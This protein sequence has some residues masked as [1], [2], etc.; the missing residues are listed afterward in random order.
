MCQS[1][2]HLCSQTFISVNHCKT[3]WAVTS[4]RQHWQR[5]GSAVA[6]T[7]SQ[8]ASAVNGQ[9]QRWQLKCALDMTTKRALPLS[10]ART[11]QADNNN[12]ESGPAQAELGSESGIESAKESTVRA[13][14][15]EFS[16][17]R[18]FSLVV[19]AVAAVACVCVCPSLCLRVAL[20][21]VSSTAETN[22][23]NNNNA[24]RATTTATTMDCPSM[25]VINC[26]VSSCHVNFSCIQIIVLA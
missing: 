1:S 10:L 8:S 24:N 16:Q 2:S 19:A 22:S 14:L 18:L 23:S 7:Q 17:V 13:S 5:C 20:I 25:L 11:R 9:W 12:R 3:V 6:V 21:K 15:A 26:H 4:Q